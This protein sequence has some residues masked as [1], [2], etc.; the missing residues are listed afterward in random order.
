VRLFC[1]FGPGD[2]NGDL[3]DWKNGR[4]SEYSIAQTYS[5]EVFSFCQA[6]SISLL[7]ISSNPRTASSI[8]GDLQV[9]NVPKRHYGSSIG[10]YWREMRYAAKL[11]GLAVKWRADVAIIDSGTMPSWGYLAMRLAGIRVIPKLHNAFWAI[12]RR[13]S[14]FKRLLQWIA[15]GL[16]LRLASERAL[17]VS[18][19]CASQWRA[20]TGTTFSPTLFL[21]QFQPTQFLPEAT[22]IADQRFRVIFSSRV[23][24]NKGIVELIRAAHQC[25]MHL[26]NQFRFDIFGAGSALGHAVNL[27]NEL[28]L[29][30]T[31]FVH[32]QVQASMLS[33]ALHCAHVL[34][35]PTLESFPEALGKSLV[36][37]ALWGKPTIASAFVPAAKL[38]PSSCLVLPSV[39]AEHIFAALERLRSNPSLYQALAKGSP[40]ERGIFL[41]PHY[42]LSSALHEVFGLKR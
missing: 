27:V 9:S 38:L 12:D 40:A 23:E 29:Q 31:V 15:V 28:G 2:A 41:D 36:E 3:L 14:G 20:L 4:A 26:A 21:P 33:T 32:G 39:T 37:A 30:R 16:P 1:A 42:G 13:P 11:L 18:P 25:E 22:P 19:E 6:R 8:V 5:K 7:G 10:Y 34:A 24:L 35:M 17:V